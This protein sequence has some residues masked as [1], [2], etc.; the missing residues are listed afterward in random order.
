MDASQPGF[1]NRLQTSQKEGA[2]QALP[3]IALQV[4]KGQLSA[5]FLPR[6]P[7]DISLVAFST[8]FVPCPKT[9]RNQERKK[10]QGEPKSQGF[11]IE[12]SGWFFFF[13]FLFSLPSGVEHG[14]ISGC[15]SHVSPGVCAGL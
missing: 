7:T 15:P 2:R 9:W 4:P 10:R 1:L 3:S 8:V 14:V 11:D 12:D 6:I 13:F 5:R